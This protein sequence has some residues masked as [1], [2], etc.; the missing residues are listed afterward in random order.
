M[1]C[2]YKYKCCIV[3]YCDDEVHIQVQVLYCILLWRWGAYTSR[4]VYNSR[5]R[6]VYTSTIAYEYNHIRHV[7]GMYVRHVYDICT[8]NI[9][10]KSRFHSEVCAYLC[11]R[12]MLCVH[13]LLDNLYGEPSLLPMFIKQNH[14]CISQ[15]IFLQIWET[16]ELQFFFEC[17]GWA[18]AVTRV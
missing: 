18:L 7:F 11:V 5:Q 15:K 1:R 8:D 17:S 16:S 12:I 14:I 10:F 2:I 6:G 13:T 9:Y 3:Y 4:I